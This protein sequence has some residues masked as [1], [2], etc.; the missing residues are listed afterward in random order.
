MASNG[1]AQQ[2]ENV[3]SQKRSTEAASPAPQESPAQVGWYFVEK[4]YTTLNQSPDQVPLFYNRRSSLVWGD[5]GDVCPMVTGRQEIAEKIK[6]I[7]FKDC[8]VRVTNVDSQASDKGII[9]QVMGEMSNDQRP[10]RRFVQTFFLAEQQNG[11]FVLNDIF[12]YLKEEEE[13]IEN[14]PEDVEDEALPE[15]SVPAV[16]EATTVEETPAEEATEVEEA[17]APAPAEPEPVVAKAEEPVAI[18]PAV[19]EIPTPVVAAAAEPVNGTPAV[20]AEPEVAAEEVPAA[21]EVVEEAP[22]PKVEASVTPAEPTPAATPPPPAPA[23]EKPSAPPPV[24]A[25]VVPA[26]PPKPTTWASLLGSGSAQITKPAPSGLQMP[27]QPAAPVPQAQPVPVAQPTPAA[28]QAA[29]PTSPASQG[30]QSV[31][32]SSG[33]HARPVSN[34]VPQELQAQAYLKNV[35]ANVDE[36]ALREALSKFGTIKSMDIARNKNCAFVEFESVASYKAAKAASPLQIGE[37]NVLVEERRQGTARPSGPGFGQNRNPV[38][39]PRDG[40]PG[41]GRGGFPRPEGRFDNR[42]G[43]EPGQGSRGGARGGSGRGGYQARPR[44][45]PTPTTN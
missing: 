15:E 30:W 21:A 34:A 4:Y 28:P 27:P 37:S 6:S 36:N 2:G 44:G 22:A 31:S 35:T 40:R 10:N 38:G 24:A 33:R 23:A 26:A 13:E 20:E 17:S 5:E 29:T 39:G 25:P 1:Y 11:Y 19:P 32:G 9:I 41:Q 7:E 12:R 43:R 14:L 18:A 45:T 3:Q 16:E 8:K 42:D